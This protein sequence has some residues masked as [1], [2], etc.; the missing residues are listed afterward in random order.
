MSRDHFNLDG[1]VAVVGGASRGIG[2]SIAKI[3]AE[4]GAQV[5]VSSRRYDSCRAVADAIAAAGGKAEAMPCHLGEISQIE[6]LFGHVE[7]K[8]GRV[9]VLVNNAAANPYYGHVLDI[10]VEA[11]EKTLDV[12][13]RGYFYMSVAAAKL[14]R[15]GSGGSIINVASVGGVTPGDKRPCIP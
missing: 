4:Y 15:K 3:L 12:N 10:P 1:K 13:V 9:D 11:F 14:M 6:A 8:Y 7:Q 2:E 5:I